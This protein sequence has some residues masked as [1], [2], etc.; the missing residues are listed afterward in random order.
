MPVW[1][2]V[3]W[4]EFWW[5]SQ[6]I[7]SGLLLCLLILDLP[8]SFL[9]T[10]ILML[11]FNPHSHS[12][13]IL[14]LTADHALSLNPARLLRLAFSFPARVYNTVIRIC[15]AHSPL[16]SSCPCF[17]AGVLNFKC[18][19]PDDLRWS[20]C[21]NNRNK[22]HNKCNA[23]ESSPNHPP[24]P[25]CVEKLSSTKLVLGAKKLGNCSSKAF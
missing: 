11:Y 4:L 22:V 7:M 13:G 14:W 19:M 20:W 1:I 6:S 12:W 3:C 25:Q 2:Q 9:C 18:L 8:E 17:K 23:L 21:K 5:S 24:N 16:P 15:C 10:Y